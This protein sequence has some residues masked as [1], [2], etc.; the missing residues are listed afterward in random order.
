[1]TA[2]SARNGRPPQDR[3][4]RAFGV[5]PSWSCCSTACSLPL[6]ALQTG[7]RRHACLV[8]N[9]AEFVGPAA[10][11]CASLEHGDGTNLPSS[12]RTAVTRGQL[13]PPSCLGLGILSWALGQMIFTYEWVRLDQPPLALHRRS[14]ISERIPFLLLGTAASGPPGACHAP[15][16]RLALDGLMI[17]TA[18]VT[19]SWYFILGPVMQQ[20]PR[21]R[22]PRPWLRPTHWPTSC[23]SPAS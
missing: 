5:L 8:V 17:M 21:V 12:R 16:T 10:R 11:V 3:P 23:L 4:A 1:M 7:H 22:L 18:A 20:G 13:G 9:S 15:G 6:R 19:F 2:G 14:R